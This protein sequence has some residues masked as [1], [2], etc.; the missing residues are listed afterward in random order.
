MPASALWRP[1]VIPKRLDFTQMDPEL[2]ADI[3]QFTHDPFGYVMYCF[4]WGKPGTILAKKRGPR[5][6]QAKILKRIGEKLRAGAADA[7]EVIREAIASGH[8]VGKSALVSWLIKWAMDTCVDTRGVV[9]ANTQTQLLTKTWPELSK[10]HNLSLTKAWMNLT[11]TALIS[12]MPGHEKDWRFDA[13]PWSQT[14]TEAFAGLHNEGKRLLLI[15]DE[16]SAIIPKVWEVAEGALTDADTEII[17]CVFGNPTRNTGDFHGCFHK[18]KHVWTCTQ[19]DSRTCEG[20]NLV[21]INK[22]IRDY[23]EDSDFVRVRVRGVFPRAGSL[24]FIAN[25][26]V[27]A[28]ME[29]PC[30]GYELQGKVLGVDVARHG[31]DQSCIVRRQGRKVWPMKRYRIRDLMQL[32]SRVAEE[33]EAFQPDMVFVDATG[34]GWGVVDRLHQMGY[35]QVVGVQVGEKPHDESRYRKLRDELWGRLR[36]AILDGL[37]LPDDPELETDLTAPEYGFDDRQR[38][39]MESKEDMKERGLAS[40]DAAD[41]LAVSYFAPVGPTRSKRDT[42]RKRISTRAKKQGKGGATALS[43]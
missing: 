10:W 20:I 32:A 34:M 8:G 3:G 17:W 13:V 25:D 18:K 23:G 6:W 19:V 38:Y 22:W 12:N 15:F 36:D 29:R 27:R 7:G 42:W 24:Q 33:I 41:A 4:P 39:V 21:Q 30:Q 31:D 5:A 37:S 11:A 9:T 26:D 16:A 1:K 2:A 14:N 43:R 28:A 35:K 40:P